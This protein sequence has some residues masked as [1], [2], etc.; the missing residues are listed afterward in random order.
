MNIKIIANAACLKNLSILTLNFH[1]LTIFF[2]VIVLDNKIIGNI[3][4]I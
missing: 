2:R 1:I 4:E 3:F